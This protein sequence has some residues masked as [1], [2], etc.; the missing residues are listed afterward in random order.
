MKS[1]CILALFLTACA[2]NAESDIVEPPDVVNHDP[3]ADSFGY[4]SDYRGMARCDLS[5]FEQCKPWIRWQDRGDPPPD[6]N[7]QKHYDEGVL[8]QNKLTNVQR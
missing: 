5:K 4:D 3:A 2:F 7:H 8:E 6:R 1:F